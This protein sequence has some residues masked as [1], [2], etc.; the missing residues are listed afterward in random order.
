MRVR[1]IGAMLVAV[2]T[3]L[4]VGCGGG[5]GDLPS[6]V[7][8]GSASKADS[9]F[10]EKNLQQALDRLEKKIGAGAGAAVFKIEPRSI[11]T[12]LVVGGQ[13]KVAAI[14]KDGKAL[15]VGAGDAPQQKAL[16]LKD[17]PAAAPDRIITTLEQQ[18][19]VKFEDIDYFIASPSII[20]GQQPSWNVYVK[21][22]DGHFTAALDG[23][24]VKLVGTSSGGGSSS[25]NSSDGGSSGGGSSSGAQDTADCIQKAG[26][27]IQKIQECTQ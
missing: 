18:H 11:K 7:S 14:N 21:N 2:S 26:G 1:T 22:Q 16:P 5:V 17:I 24:G 8:G 9:L 23:G 19:E 25:D 6:D 3:V 20:E 12:T 15:I 27:D 10:T 13:Q 4:V